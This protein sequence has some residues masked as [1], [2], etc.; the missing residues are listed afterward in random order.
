MAVQVVSRSILT[1]TQ[2]RPKHFY[3][4]AAS[5]PGYAMCLQEVSIQPNMILE[6]ALEPRD[7]A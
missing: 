1:G 5:G 7:K 3:V 2:V 4:T 6:C